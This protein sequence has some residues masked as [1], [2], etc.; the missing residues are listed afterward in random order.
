MSQLFKTTPNKDFVIDY[1]QTHLMK[2]KNYYKITPE[3]YKQLL[4][5]DVVQSFLEEIKKHYH[6][7]K[8]IYVERKITYPRF[9]TIIR[10]CCKSNEI[11]YVSNIKYRNSYY[12][13]EYYFYIN[14]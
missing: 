3:I 9:I 6:I 4:Y 12:E 2:E 8:Q 5:K 13:I 11:N 7:S 14:T 10:H 1:I